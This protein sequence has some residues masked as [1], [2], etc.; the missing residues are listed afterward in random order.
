MSDAA[1]AALSGQASRFVMLLRDFGHLDE[2]G[3]SA[4]LLDAADASED[5]G[6]ARVDL[7]EMRRIAARHL[8]ER[9]AAQLRDGEGILS[10]DWRLL[11]S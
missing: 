10:E 11:F 4:L 8:F 9:S 1:R 6:V 3:V 2:A 7:E 5:S